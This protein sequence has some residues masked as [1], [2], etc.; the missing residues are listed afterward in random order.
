MLLIGFRVALS[1]VY[2]HVA[3][4]VDSCGKLSTR[5]DLTMRRGMIV[6]FG[7]SLK[8]LLEASGQ[9]VGALAVFIGYDVSYVSRWTNNHRLPSARNIDGIIERICAFFNEHTTEEQ[10]IRIAFTLGFSQEY[11]LETPADICGYSDEENASHG[12]GL[13]SG[14]GRIIWSDAL[15]DFLKARYSEHGGKTTDSLQPET[16]CKFGREYVTYEN[17]VT[18]IRES[19]AD[20][21]QT[22]GCNAVEVITLVDETAFEDD[23]A[24]RF[25]NNVLGSTVAD[26]PVH[27]SIILLGKSLLVLPSVCHDVPIHNFGLPPQVQVSLYC[28]DDVEAGDQNIW[29]VGDAL[30]IISLSLPLGSERVA[31]ISREKNLIQDIRSSAL[32]FIRTHAPLF[33]ACNLEQITDATVISRLLDTDDVSN[34]TEL[35]DS[36]G[37]GSGIGLVVSSDNLLWMD[38]DSFLRDMLIRAPGAALVLYQ[39]SFC[40]CQQN[41]ECSVCIDGFVSF[42]EDNPGVKLYLMSDEG[43]FLHREEM[44][45]CLLASKDI[46]CQRRNGAAVWTVST[47]MDLTCSIFKWLKDSLGCCTPQDC[48]NI[49]SGDRA[50]DWLHQVARRRALT[51]F[52]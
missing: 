9:K 38:G 8:T 25:Y 50:L 12:K 10:K 52:R 17:N 24:S 34:V 26:V 32:H 51:R 48:L 41:G 46:L 49:L 27:V 11:C 28:N 42:L 13:S 47:D 15:F 45:G 19:I 36:S 7:D 30:A 16:N 22:P 33:H 40:D 14:Q 2:R 29:L 4:T 18:A 1:Y 21:A 37:M 39:S 6:T 23:E 3:G 31:L 20:V 44:D 43:G 35:G 5:A